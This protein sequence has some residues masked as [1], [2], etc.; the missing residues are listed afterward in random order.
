MIHADQ[1]IGDR[2]QPGEPGIL[3][4]KVEQGFSRRYRPTQAFISLLLGKDESA[5]EPNQTFP[6]RAYDASPGIYRDERGRV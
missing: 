1:Q 3:L 2:M 4:Q 5:V 6:H